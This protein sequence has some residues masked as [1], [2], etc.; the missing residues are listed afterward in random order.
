MYTLLLVKAANSTVP[1][2]P[3]SSRAVVS[4]MN[5]LLEM[6]CNYYSSQPQDKTDT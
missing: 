5:V 6:Q 3:A 4:G 1:Q 2:A